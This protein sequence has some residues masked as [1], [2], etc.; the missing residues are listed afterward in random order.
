MERRHRHGPGFLVDVEVVDGV[1]VQRRADEDH[2]RRVREGHD[3]VCVFARAPKRKT[4]SE[5][6][7]SDEGRKTLAELYRFKAI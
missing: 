7:Q 5:L 4:K 6:P 2:R 1:V 3:L